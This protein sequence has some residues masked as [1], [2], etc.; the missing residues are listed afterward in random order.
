MIEVLEVLVMT[1][2]LS[3]GLFTWLTREPFRVELKS[4]PGGLERSGS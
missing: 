2:F 4:R 3:W 1:A